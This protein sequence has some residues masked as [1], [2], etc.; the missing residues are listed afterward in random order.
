[1]GKVSID[2]TKCLVC[3]ACVGS[4]PSLALFLAENSVEWH[5]EKCTFCGICEKVCP[6]GA[7]KVER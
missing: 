7:I 4:C 5:E 3:G 2:E 1:M 6:V